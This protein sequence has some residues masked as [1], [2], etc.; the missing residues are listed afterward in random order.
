MN[1][2]TVFLIIFLVSTALLIYVEK[3]GIGSKQNQNP[4]QNTSE[5]IENGGMYNTAG[6]CVQTILDESRPDILSY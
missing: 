1:E 3:T 4:D 2:K 5:C 6:D